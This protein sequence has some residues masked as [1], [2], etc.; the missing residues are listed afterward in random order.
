L[1]KSAQAAG[2]DGILILPPYYS[3]ISICIWTAAHVGTRA[4][5]WAG[6]TG[7]QICHPHLEFPRRSLSDSRRGSRSPVPRECSPLRAMSRMCLG[8]TSGKLRS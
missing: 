7:S 6:K 2:A 8:N 3:C 1:A 4:R 5:P